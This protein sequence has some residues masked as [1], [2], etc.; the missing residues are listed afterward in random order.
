MLAKPELRSLTARFPWAVF[1]LAPLALPLVIAVAAL[2]FEIWFG[3]HAGGV[4]SYLTGPAAGPVTARLATRVFTAYN[5]LAVYVAPLLFA[6]AFYWLGSRQRLRP[7]WIVT[8]VAIICVLGG[9]QELMFYDKGYLGGGVLSFQ[10]AHLLF[11]LSP[12]RGGCGPRRDKSRHCR[13][14][15][16]VAHGA[17]GGFRPLGCCISRKHRLSGNLRKVLCHV[18]SRYEPRDMLR[19]TR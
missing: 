19:F 13:L 3:N 16:V 18:I 14:R 2:Y 15:L 7:G 6:W 5:T 4:Y 11:A 9:F 17:Q 8:G 10:S 1:G 12:F